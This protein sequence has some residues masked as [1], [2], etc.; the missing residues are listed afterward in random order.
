VSNVSGDWAET[1]PEAI[2]DGI[3]RIPLPMPTDSL[4][5]ANVYALVSDE[6]VTMIDGGWALTK[7]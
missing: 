1:G 7:A 3:F 5:A 2:A 4:R 6:G